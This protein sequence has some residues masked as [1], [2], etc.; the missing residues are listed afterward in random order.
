MTRNELKVLN[1]NGFLQYFP[2]SADPILPL[3]TLSY[4]VATQIKVCILGHL[5]FQRGTLLT[6]D[7]NVDCRIDAE[8]QC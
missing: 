7:S 5:G 1:A 4:K 8:L 2:E 6:N 3:L